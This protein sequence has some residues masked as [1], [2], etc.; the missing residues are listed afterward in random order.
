MTGNALTR[1]G[2]ILFGIAVLMLFV[3]PVEA[4]LEDRAEDRATAEALFAA[5]REA[6]RQGDY[7]SARD[8]FT[9]SNH[10]DPAVGTVLNLAICEEHLGLLASAWQ[11]YQEVIQALARGDERLPV[12]RARA[13]AIDA[14]VPRLTIRLAPS[15]PAQTKVS[16]GAGALTSA[17]FGTALPLDP[18][19]HEIVATAPGR[20]ARR[21][22]VV[23]AEGA[24]KELVVEPGPPLPEPARPQQAVPARKRSP[25]PQAGP[26]SVQ[27]TA[28][29]VI[30]GAGIA[31]LI[32]S[33][34][35]GVL[36]IDRKQTVDRE[37]G[38]DGFC[39]DAAF[40]AAES[41]KTLASVSTVAFVF[42]LVG[43]GSGTYLVLSSGSSGDP[44]TRSTGAK[45]ITI[46]GS[47]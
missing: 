42:G 43:V 41:G 7:R 37:C 45:M 13:A 24:R 14:R 6:L 21:Y 47:F 19:K 28:G 2:T 35:T 18:G 34:V 25:E 12:A 4:Q 11:R 29:F 36:V 10:L 3:C 31:A 23:L 40:E 46:G 27:R 15:A 17:S 44:R 22:D 5:G 33:A 30:G 1:L 20:S 39:S 9:E 26:R 8:K 16:R 32:T 38:P